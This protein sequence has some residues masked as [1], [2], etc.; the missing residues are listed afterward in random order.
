MSGALAGTRV[1][2][3]S[4]VMA[5]PYASHL[6]RLMGAEVIKI[7][8]PTG[9]PARYTFSEKPGVDSV[10]FC[11]MNLNKKSVTLNLKSPRGREMFQALSKDLPPQKK[12]R[13]AAIQ[14]EL[15]KIQAEPVTLE[16]AAAED[17]KKLRSNGTG[18]VLLVNF[19]ST[20]G[21]PSAPMVPFTVP[22]TSSPMIAP[23]MSSTNIKS[24]MTT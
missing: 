23:V 11:L 15:A 5:G 6:L 21:T 8:A 14:E 7:E 4:H 1:V 13:Y 17:L 3:F 12:A 16:M 9:E 10:F 20:T 22:V 2:D 19:W 18:K 24:L